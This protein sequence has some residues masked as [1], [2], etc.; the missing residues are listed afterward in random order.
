MNNVTNLR[1]ATQCSYTAQALDSLMDSRDLL[2]I[3]HM[4][5]QAES[6]H[7]EDTIRAVASVIDV[8]NRMLSVAQ[9]E[10]NAG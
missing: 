6:F 1:P 9:D 10:L 4:A 7:D 3:T 8:A 2:T 5:L